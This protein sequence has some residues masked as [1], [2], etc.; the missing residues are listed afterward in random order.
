MNNKSQQQKRPEGLL[1]AG[2]DPNGIAASMAVT[3]DDRVLAVDDH[4]IQ[5]IL[6]F[7]VATGD[8]SFTLLI[9][10][11]TSGE[12]WEIE[13]ERGPGEFLGIEFANAAV[14]GLKKC[15]NHCIFCFVRQMPAG[16]RPSLYDLDDD[17]RMSVSRG[18]YITL[19]NLSEQEMARILTV[20]PSPLYIS[21]HAWNPRVRQQ[22]MG[23]ERAGELPEQLRRLSAAGINLHTQIVL[24]PGYNDGAVLEETV[25]RLAAL[26]PQVQTIGIVPVGLT[27]FRHNLPNLQ[28][29]TPAEARNLI[30]NGR[31]WQTD[32]L[33]RYGKR[34]V[35]F[36]DE[37]YVLGEMMAELPPAE[38]YDGFEQ[39]ENGVGMLRLF[40]EEW[41]AAEAEFASQFS[42]FGTQAL[43]PPRRHIITGTIAAPFL[44]TC[45]ERARRLIP[46][47]TYEIHAVEN[48]FF[49]PKITV[50]GLVT[51]T[52]IAAQVG[53]L[54]GDEFFVPRTMLREGE[55]IFL[56]N[57]DVA[58]LET[59]LNG[60]ARVIDC[61][62]RA[63][64]EALSGLD[65]TG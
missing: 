45:A 12:L 50:A 62:G 26:A 4:P 23:N 41:N 59:R 36:A 52:D 1:I 6:D 40:A 31:V 21:V 32:F 2:V 37:L 18:T 55:D 27:R 38:A 46:N 10:K 19:T 16:L 56:D 22:L 13:I 34:L 58:W 48:H 61:T 57:R 64:F 43:F 51:A 7:Q 14:D 33:Y 63:F 42:A 15:R 25:Y 11:Q 9:E 39:L 5:D 60:R 47:L 35:Y 49:G 54:G 28:S 44:S 20:R 8:V 29:L 24:V 17:Y 3:I 53:D 65:K 30:V